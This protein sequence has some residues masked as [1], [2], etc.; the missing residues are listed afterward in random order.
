MSRRTAFKDIKFGQ[1]QQSLLWQAGTQL[2]SLARL[3]DDGFILARHAAAARALLA[4]FAA[5]ADEDAMRC[6]QLLRHAAGI[7]TAID[8]LK[9]LLLADVSASALS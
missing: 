9:W 3:A 4:R 1:Y 2:T 6:A 5:S 7:D 8:E